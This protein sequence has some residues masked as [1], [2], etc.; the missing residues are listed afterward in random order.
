MAGDQNKDRLCRFMSRSI[1]VFDQ[2]RVNL[3]ARGRTESGAHASDDLNESTGGK[4]L[5]SKYDDGGL[6]IMHT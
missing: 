2:S 3:P 1:L 6:V 5:R 4:L